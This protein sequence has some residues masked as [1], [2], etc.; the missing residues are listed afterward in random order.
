[1]YSW[2]QSRPVVGL[3]E[4][5]VKTKFREVEEYFYFTFRKRRTLYVPPVT[6]N[7]RKCGTIAR[8]HLAKLGVKK[9]GMDAKLPSL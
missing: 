2:G 6:R 9:F 4:V 3:V 8:T 5:W 1:M 7:V